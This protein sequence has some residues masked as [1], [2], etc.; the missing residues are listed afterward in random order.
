MHF[1]SGMQADSGGLDDSFNGALLQHSD[2]AFINYSNR[3]FVAHSCFIPVIIPMCPTSCPLNL[4]RPVTARVCDRHGGTTGRRPTLANSGSRRTPPQRGDFPAACT[5]GTTRP[6][7]V[8]P[9]GSPILTFS[10]WNPTR[11]QRRAEVNP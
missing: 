8:F 1:A 10:G 9:R 11:I 3:K 4:F 5:T 2:L 7:K 6:P